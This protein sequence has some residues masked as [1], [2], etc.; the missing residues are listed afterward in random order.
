MFRTENMESSLAKG[1]QVVLKCESIERL[2]NST[3]RPNFVVL[4]GIFDA[5]QAA[6]IEGRDFQNEQFAKTIQPERWEKLNP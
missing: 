5:L 3:A 1:S 2:T 6:L 4:S